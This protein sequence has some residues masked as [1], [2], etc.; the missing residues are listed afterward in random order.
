[1]PTESIYRLIAE[2]PPATLTEFEQDDALWSPWER[3][4][5]TR[6]DGDADSGSISYLYG[7]NWK[8]PASSVADMA[9]QYPT[10]VFTLEHADEFGE[11]GNRTVYRDG[12]QCTKEQVDPLIFYWAGWETSE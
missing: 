3:F 6:H 9:A 1:M 11:V 8:V 4:S 2:G 7:D 5:I 12:R 10:L